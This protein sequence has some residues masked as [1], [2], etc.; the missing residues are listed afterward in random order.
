MSGAVVSYGPTSARRTY[1]CPWSSVRPRPLLSPA[2]A[3]HRYSAG[4]S[5]TRHLPTCCSPDKLH[6][7]SQRCGYHCARSHDILQNVTW[8]KCLHTSVQDVGRHRWWRRPLVTFYA[9]YGLAR[10]IPALHGW[11]LTI[12]SGAL[13]LTDVAVTVDLVITYCRRLAVALAG[14]SG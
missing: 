7:Y 9:A 4:Y 3:A 6:E 8:W 2:A 14:E 12:T 13:F 10:L 5:P 1:V 11:P